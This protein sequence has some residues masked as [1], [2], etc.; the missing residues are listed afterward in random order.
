MYTHNKGFSSKENGFAIGQKGAEVQIIDGTGN[1]ILPNGKTVTGNVIGNVTGNAT[2]YAL[3]SE[4][5]TATAAGDGTGQISANAT[6][7]TVT[8]DNADKIITLPAPIVGLTI[9]IINGTTGYELR[10]S[11]PATIAI[12]GGVSAAAESA[13]AASMIL[14]LT[15]VSATAWIG[16]SQTAAGV[17]GVVQVAAD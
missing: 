5:R 14:T 9:R 16:S 15:C 10:T 12:N 3:K 4:A 17:V 2:G 11:A 1:I 7:V 13:I 8:S 6:M